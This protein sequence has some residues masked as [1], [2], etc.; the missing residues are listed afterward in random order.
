[1]ALADDKDGVFAYQAGLGLGL[2]ASDHVIFDL[3]YRYFGTLD[4]EFERTDGSVLK[5]DI[6]SHSLLLGLRLQF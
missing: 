2:K 6:S 5:S 3:G 4:P 1:M